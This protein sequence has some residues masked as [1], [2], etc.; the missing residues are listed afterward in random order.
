MTDFA[1]VS[2]RQ[3]RAQVER[4]LG[5]ASFE[6]LRRPGPGGLTLEPLYH[7]SPP[8]A[9]RIDLLPRAPG[10]PGWE[11]CQRYADPDPEV[12]RA[13]LLADS[14]Q[15]VDGAWLCLDAA[16]RLG[17]AP[18]AEGAEAV[19][20]RD[21]I[22]LYDVDSFCGLLDGTRSP[23][24]WID[25]GGNALP[26]AA[27]VV[28]ALDRLG[29]DAGDA[30]LRFCADPL[31][32]L[33]RD[34]ELPASHATLG[35]EAAML[36]RQ[37]QEQWPA[38]RAWIASGAPYARA[39]ADAPLELGAVVAT[40]V[41]YLRYASAA[42][43]APGAVADQMV[44]SFEIDRDLLVELTKLRAAR[45][46]WAK[47]LVACEAEPA[48]A[49]LHAVTG[50]RTLTEADPWLNMLRATV[51]TTAAVLGGA[52]SITVTPFD[53]C[54]GRSDTR[55]LRVARNTHAILDE[56]SHLG[57]VADPG[58]GSHAIET[59]TDELARAAWEQLRRLDT[60]GMAS[61]LIAG[62]DESVARC[63]VGE[64]AAQRRQALSSGTSQVLGVSVHPPP[65]DTRLEREALDR[66]G[67][68]ERIRERYRGH[69]TPIAL[70][71]VRA[72][73]AGTDARHGPGPLFEALVAAA[74]DG[75]TLW[76]LGDALRGGEE[77]ER[78]APLIAWPDEQKAPAAP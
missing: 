53:A 71:R 22:A 61:A 52:Q 67:M 62:G 41:E 73:V 29:I 32:S 70:E 39:G 28:A 65:G 51:Q 12:A 69:A 17:V 75:A 8:G 4:E 42:G 77:R 74:R 15:G 35:W 76:E 10:D 47:V 27:L 3:W 18:D 55:G 68:V 1:L 64:A 31:G 5:E 20:G 48:A 49:Y 25:A 78:A 23:S 26:A 33:A 9:T 45:C 13:Q 50:A 11:R 24:L 56:E 60:Q 58:A 59:L 66:A 57:E 34:G 2:P 72:A 43:V 54:L 46:V 40:V 21:G 38:A 6:T 36:A 30:R 14:A 19:I 37:C 63:A 44:L 7:D 16:A